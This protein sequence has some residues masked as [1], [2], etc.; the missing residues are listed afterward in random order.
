MEIAL[1][2]REKGD[3]EGKELDCPRWGFTVK[4]INQFDNPDLY[5]HQKEGV[6][7]YGIKYPGNASDAGLRKN[8]IL[9]QIEGKEVKTLEDITTAHKAAMDNIQKNH[10]ILLTVL[11][12]GLMHQIVLDFGMNY[13]N[14]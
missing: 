5:F 1:T 10:R 7:V 14:E 6:F 2:P 4:T 11:R 9:L 13:E 8:D 12:N 3:V